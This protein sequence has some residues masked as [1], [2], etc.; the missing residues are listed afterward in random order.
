MSNRRRP[1]KKAREKKSLRPPEQAPAPVPDPWPKRRVGPIAIVAVV[2]VDRGRKFVLAITRPGPAAGRL[3]GQRP[4]D[5]VGY[6]ARGPDRGLR[7]RRDRNAE[8]RQPGC[9]RGAFHP[10]DFLYST[11]AARPHLASH[12]SPTHRVT[13]VRDNGG[14]FL[15]D[16]WTTLAEAVRERGHET[17]AAAGRLR[18]ARVV[19][20][21][22]G[23][24]RL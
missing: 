8:P 3:T 9:R 11:H 24:R 16:R 15:D 12:R 23:L 22:P 13:G 18:A 17:F 1:K 21:E 5:H 20:I 14:Y 6:D 7:L 2:A 10:G 19:G 4:A